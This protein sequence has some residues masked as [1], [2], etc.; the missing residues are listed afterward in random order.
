[1]IV[2]CTEVF[3][4]YSCFGLCMAIELI[5]TVIC[6]SILGEWLH[7]V[8]VELCYAHQGV[9]LNLTASIQV[10]LDELFLIGKYVV[11]VG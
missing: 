1:M 3:H 8:C 6:Y 2:F 11:F 7:A 5:T 9:L 10:L 4:Y